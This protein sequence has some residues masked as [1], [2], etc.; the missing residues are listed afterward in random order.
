MQSLGQ[1][2]TVL[3]LSAMVHTMFCRLEFYSK[4]LDLINDQLTGSSGVLSIILYLGIGDR[5]LS[6]QVF[7]L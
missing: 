5:M 4:T 1:N 7:V 6:V 3:V 2:T